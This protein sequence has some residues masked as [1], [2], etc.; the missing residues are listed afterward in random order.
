MT[1]C[2]SCRALLLVSLL[3]WHCTSSVEVL[4]GPPSRDGSSGAAAMG[5]ISPHGGAAGRAIPAA[6]AGGSASLPDITPCLELGT[7]LECSLCCLELF[8]EYPL[9]D[10]TTERHCLCVEPRPCGTLCDPSHCGEN[11]NLAL[12]SSEC[13]DC[14]LEA[15][16]TGAC[17]AV[18][19][20]CDADPTCSALKSCEQGCP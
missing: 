10:D 9:P 16:A 8:A 2:R 4:Q 7:A 14:R 18:Y 19:A 15:D 11:P 1:V 12:E 5:G 3:G 17:N 13:L 6:G 20:R